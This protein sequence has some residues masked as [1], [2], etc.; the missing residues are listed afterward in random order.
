MAHT[1]SVDEHDGQ[2]S[3]ATIWDYFA[4][5]PEVERHDNLSYE[6]FYSEFMGRSKPVIITDATSNWPALTKWS[7]P[8]F[9]E[10]YGDVIVPNQEWNNQ[11]RSMAEYIDA[12]MISTA[13]NPGPYISA[14]HITQL[15]PELLCDFHPQS[16]WEPNW[17]DNP[18]FLRGF[19]ADHSLRHTSALVLNMGG[20]HSTIRDGIHSDDFKIQ[21]FVT[22]VVGEKEWLFFPPNQGNY[23]YPHR[24]EFTSANS[25]SH[26]PVADI[27][28]LVEFPL[29]R[30]ATPLRA[31][32]GAGD[33]LCM[34]SGWWHTTRALSESIAVVLGIANR[35]NWRQVR[36]DVIVNAFARHKWY[37]API[38][39]ALYAGSITA[40][41]LSEAFKNR[42]T[43]R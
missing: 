22:Q 8:F 11:R 31:R 40:F 20:K 35:Y 14:L 27:A 38:G 43:E 21:T 4:K 41:R 7:L 29:L 13:D 17:L 32:V 34:P 15:F 6:E 16:V 30:R 5:V 1:M 37:K 25:R 26:V 36:R 39:A 24:Y 10:R 2:A 12:M 18:S 33:M 23:L 28:D 3:H 9:R 42:A 19:P